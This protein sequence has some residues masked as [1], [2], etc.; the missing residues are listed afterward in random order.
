[1]DA[2]V[3]QISLIKKMGITIQLFFYKY[4]YKIFKNI[5]LN[6]QKKIPLKKFETVYKKKYSC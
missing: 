3:G 6:P 4:D 1:M 5:Y 2:K